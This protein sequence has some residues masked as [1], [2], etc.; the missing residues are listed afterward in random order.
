MKKETY[1]D[2]HFLEV[3]LENQKLKTFISKIEK[4]TELTF[5][6]KTNK[7]SDL[8]QIEDEAVNMEYRSF[9]D[10]ND[11]QAY[12]T[13]NNIKILDFLNTSPLPTD[14]ID[15]WKQVGR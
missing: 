14:K 10:L 1:I 9:F 13:A 7:Y 11:L 2:I 4:V 6:S 12:F 8:C 3:N 5:L 15:F